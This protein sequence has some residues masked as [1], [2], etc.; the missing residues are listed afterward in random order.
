[1]DGLPEATSVTGTVGDLLDFNPMPFSACLSS[2]GMRLGAGRHTFA[3]G[4]STAPFQ[5]TSVLIHSASS[6]QPPA[7]TRKARV[8]KWNS[9]SRQIAVGSGPA[10]YL[11]VAQNYSKGWIASFDDRTLKPIRIDGWQQGYVVPAGAG[12]TVTMVMSTEGLYRLLLF[13]GAMFLLG[14]AF[15]ALMPSR[16]P[17][18]VV[19][20]PRSMPSFW[21]LLVGSLIVLG[22]VSGPLALLIL[23]L[24]LAARRW[25]SRVMA[26]IAFCAF[27]AAGVAA[28]WDPAHLFSTS[29]GAFG[30]PAQLASVIALATVFASMV[31]DRAKSRKTQNEVSPGVSP[32]G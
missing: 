14:L 26:A 13:L 31:V 27:V 29:A 19:C 25:G 18:P 6:S 11:V 17:S 7:A 12:G 23:P 2:A 22:L 15:L 24:V 32:D 5:I 1:M 30:A 4:F 21:I 3:E 16:K 10:T 9:D 20:G 28:A 8:E